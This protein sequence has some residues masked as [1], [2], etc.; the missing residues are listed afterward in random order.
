MKRMVCLVL[1]AWI[2]FGAVGDALAQMIFL[3]GVDAPTVTT[4]DLLDG[5]R[6]AG[7]TI[8]VQEV[9]GLAISVRSGGT[10]QEVNA[11]I[12][13]LGINSDDISD[14][15]DAF[16]AGEKLILSFSR[17]IR[18]NQFDFN[19]LGAGESFAVAVDGMAPIE[20]TYEGLT[21]KGSGFFDT[22]LV[23]AANTEI[24][25]FTTGA[26]VIGLDGIDVT[27]L[28]PSHGLTLSLVSSNGVSFV[29]AMFDAPAITN[30][31][32]QHRAGLADSN[33]WNTI[34][35]PFVS[36]S[37]WEVGTTNLSGFYRVIVE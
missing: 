34:S 9:G 6:D 10:N 37:V 32:L 26:S 30:Y 20:I 17:D 35:T 31:V 18:I 3:E 16:E 5:T 4:G 25:F 7:V 29:A 11:T 33:G 28:E 27:V 1:T 36:N 24:E 13:S 8:N 19:R 12:E 23:V 21:H 2:V 22:N 14:V 15:T